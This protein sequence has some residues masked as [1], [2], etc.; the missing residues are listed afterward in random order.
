MDE[1]ALRWT[2]ERTRKRF[3]KGERRKSR[4]GYGATSEFGALAKELLQPL[5]DHIRRRLRDPKG[6]TP[7]VPTV[8]MNSIDPQLLAALGIDC[9]LH[10]I[11][12]GRREP[13]LTIDIGRIV[14]GELWAHGQLKNDPKHIQRIMALENL[15]KRDFAAKRAGWNQEDWSNELAYQAGNWLKDCCVRGLPD[16]FATSDGGAVDIREEARDRALALREQVMWA[17]PAIMPCRKEPQPWTDFRSDLYGGGRARFSVAFVRTFYK[18]TEQEIR[19]AFRHDTMHQH[20]DAVNTLGIVPFKINEPVLEA[21]KRYLPGIKE[22]KVA[23]CR[24]ALE[25]AKRH[26]AYVE[27]TLRS[28]EDVVGHRN[29]YFAAKAE[30]RRAKKKLKG[31]EVER[32]EADEDIRT[33]E[34]LRGAPFYA[35]MYCDFRGRVYPKPHFHNQRE[36]YVRAL[37]L[38]DRGQSIGSDLQWLRV[39][40]ANCLGKGFDDIYLARGLFGIGHMGIDKRDFFARKTWTL[41]EEQLIERVAKGESEEWLNADTPFQFLAACMELYAANTHGPDY[42]THLPIS[43]DATCSGLQHLC[44][45]TRDEVGG[46]LVNLVPMPAPYGLLPEYGQPRDIYG[47]VAYKVAA[48]ARDDHLLRGLNIRIDRGLI[49][50]PVMTFFYG[51]TRYGMG[52]QIEEEIGT[53]EQMAEQIEGEAANRGQ[54]LTWKVS[55]HL[56]DLVLEAIEDVVPKATEVQKFLKSCARVLAKKGKLLKWETPSG[57]PFCNRY[58]DY[59][60]KRVRAVLHGTVAKPTVAVDYLPTIRAKKA[61]IS[62][63]PNVVHALDAA[64]L[65]R[66]VNACVRAGIVDIMTVHDCFACLTPKAEQFRRIIREEFVRMYAEHDPLEEIRESVLRSGGTVGPTPEK[67]TLD[68]RKLSDYAF[69]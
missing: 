57:F 33:A 21:V 65:V 64:H 1:E 4:Q 18:E 9:L 31:A 17:N 67:G 50:R 13:G 53:E 52:D 61:V 43:F 27:E 69:S 36:D 5:T 56:V 26:L 66:T 62:V 46:A 48:L 63:A 68:L 35:P 15:A 37:F 3:E 59:K 25:A 28:D 49:K 22:K 39:H 2:E 11:I 19:A 44:A 40:T 30:L 34:R 38:F 41:A 58:H 23:A 29:R 47:A 10:G 60:T 7:A 55:R 20:V 16:V 45:M 24:G 54:L 6:D 42:R 8:L 12:I 14:Q 32:D 51:A